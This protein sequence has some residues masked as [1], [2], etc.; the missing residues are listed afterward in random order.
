MIDI[1]QQRKIMK[2]LSRGLP[3]CDEPYKELA[4]KSGVTEEL[5]LEFVQDLVETNVVSR[6]GMV[7][8]QESVG[9]V[10]N[11]IV[12]WDIPDEEVDQIGALLG[13]QE[14]ISLCYRRKRQLPDWPYN[15]FTLI[16]GKT[17]Q[18]VLAELNHIVSSN[19]IENYACDVMISTETFKHTGARQDG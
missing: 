7:I 10:E 12:V 1:N 3:I 2:H 13:L 4:E 5:L 16:H 17:K 9:Y 14:K 6:F 8:D 18:E 19:G 15:L 11:A